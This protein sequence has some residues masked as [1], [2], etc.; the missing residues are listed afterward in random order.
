M[1]RQNPFFSPLKGKFYCLVEKQTLK[2]CWGKITIE[3]NQVR[4]K[5]KKSNK[6]DEMQ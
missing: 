3:T 2:I 4:K 6:I 1:T 5:G